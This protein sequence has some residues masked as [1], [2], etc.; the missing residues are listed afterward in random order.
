MLKN[1]WEREEELA[2]LKLRSPLLQFDSWAATNPAGGIRYSQHPCF[3]AAQ[4][5]PQQGDSSRR[6]AS[7]LAAPQRWDRGRTE[8]RGWSWRS[9]SRSDIP[10]RHNRPPFR[11]RG[12]RKNPLSLKGVRKKEA[13]ERENETRPTFS[14]IYTYGTIL[15]LGLVSA[16]SAAGQD[17]RA[18]R[19][20]AM[21]KN[22]PIMLGGAKSPD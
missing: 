15:V 20:T 8:E 4:P 16:K 2:S 17:L 7:P 19:V 11:H 12:P 3:C 1:D 13:K 6:V 21:R 18:S 22:L 9:G 14:R 10:K 5:P